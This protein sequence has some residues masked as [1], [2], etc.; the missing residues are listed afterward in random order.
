MKRLLSIFI[1]VGLALVF[2]PT[3]GVEAQRVSKCGKDIVVGNGELEWITGQGID[4]G[5]DGGADLGP[6]VTGIHVQ[7]SAQYWSIPL[8]NDDDWNC[9]TGDCTVLTRN[10][11]NTGEAGSF[12]I[13]HGAGYN[14]ADG[15]QIRTI[16]D[17]RVQINDGGTAV[18]CAG[19]GAIPL[20]VW[21]THGF[22]WD[23]TTDEVEVYIDNASNTCSLRAMGNIDA[24]R[25]VAGIAYLAT[26]VGANN[27]GGKGS[28][29]ALDD[30]AYSDAQWTT[31]D[32]LVKHCADFETNGLP[33]PRVCQ[34]FNSDGVPTF[35]AV[36]M[37]NN[38]EVTF[39]EGWDGS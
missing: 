38:N 34:D 26:A 25:D 29:I 15:W 6:D 10:L 14:G 16:S 33:E 12:I 22:R 3:N 27:I 18:G 2:V 36:T 32:T 13:D 37:T 17:G 1:A 23:G 28:L 4:T 9:G 30:I 39:G 8:A 11:I 20:D 5:C 7:V 24:G 35:G 31:F 21:Y 19:P